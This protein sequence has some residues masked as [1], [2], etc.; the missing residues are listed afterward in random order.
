MDTRT[1]V[2]IALIVAGVVTLIWYRHK[3]KNEKDD[4]TERLGL[5]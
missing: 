3:K 1:I 4:Y 2:G 5:R